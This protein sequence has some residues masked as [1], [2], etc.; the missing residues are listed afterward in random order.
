VT[1]A[2]PLAPPVGV[3]ISARALTHWYGSGAK[4]V[5]VLRGID[6]DI[7][8]GSHVALQGPSGAGKS[9]LLSLVGGLERARAGTLV[10]GGHDL[11]GLRARGLAHYRRVV[12]GFVFQHFGLVDV[13]SAQE[14]VM[15]AM[16]LSGVGMAE[17]RRRALEALDAVGLS[18]RASHRPG[19]LSGGER[20]R[21]AIARA[22]VNR[23][24]LILADEPTGNLDDESAVR[25]LDLLDE[26]R[27]QR[28]STLVVV[29][30]SALVAARAQ[31]QLRLRDG[32]VQG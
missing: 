30:H 24:A 28:G 25:I 8:A 26:L 11:A 12:V 23:P 19:Q 1:Q 4:L 6:L 16:S 29:T 10:V 13:L 9:T 3:A 32:V 17:R 15:L 14:N 7:A 20:Q 27:E 21:V 18:G 5:P 31:R 2:A 22:I